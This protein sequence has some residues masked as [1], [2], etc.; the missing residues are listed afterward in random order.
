MEA[1]S[2]GPAFESHTKQKSQ[3]IDPFDKKLI[4][5]NYKEKRCYTDDCIFDRD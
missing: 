2:M 1:K 4:K 5:A 3:R